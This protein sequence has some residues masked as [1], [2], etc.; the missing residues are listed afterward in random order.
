M[1]RSL[2]SERTW[3]LLQVF[4]SY[5]AVTNSQ[6]DQSKGKYH[7]L[8]STVLPTKLDYTKQEKIKMFF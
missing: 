3:I 5:Q 8:Q 7:C 2:G 1:G 6:L 4:I